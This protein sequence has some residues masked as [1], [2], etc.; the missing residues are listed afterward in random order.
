MDHFSID[1]ETLDNKFSSAVISIGVQQ[2]DPD[3]G[4][5][6]GTFYR[7]VEID[8]A[9]KSG[10]VSGS[11]LSWW[12]GQSDKAR[13]VFGKENKVSLATALAALATWMRSMSIAPKVWGNGATFDITILEHAFV[14]GGVGLAAPWHF[15]NIRDMRTIVDAADLPPVDWPARVGVHHNA[16]D[17]AIYQAQ[18]IS[19]CWQRCR[20]S[21]KP[22]GP[23]T[24]GKA[25]S[26]APVTTA[27]EDDEL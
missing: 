10:T 2:F 7:E 9:I 26:P 22:I 24:K 12:A 16:L 3:T 19:I 18:C 21:V 20:H 15:T 6:G 1:I 4:K 17:D 27:N 8:S 13:R 23:K 25:T 5:L 11:T 14:K